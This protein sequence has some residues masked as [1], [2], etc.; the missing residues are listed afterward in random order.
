MGCKG[1]AMWLLKCSECLTY[2][3][4]V[5]RVLLS[6]LGCTVRL[7]GSYYEFVKALFNA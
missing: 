2:C 4:V 7:P 6:R 1:G 3:Y 5:T